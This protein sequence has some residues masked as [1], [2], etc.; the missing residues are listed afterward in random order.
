MEEMRAAATRARTKN[1][2]GRRAVMSAR[3]RGIFEK[4]SNPGRY[5]A[6][7]ALGINNWY[8]SPCRPY[9]VHL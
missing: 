7:I 8:V 3:F 5:Y 9:C 1:A 4:G 2:H 6:Q